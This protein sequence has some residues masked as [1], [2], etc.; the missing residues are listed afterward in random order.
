[1]K[2]FGFF[3]LLLSWLLLSGCVSV[4]L[5]ETPTPTPDAMKETVAALQTENAQL[6]TQVAGIPATIENLPTATPLPSATPT[7]TSTPTA[8]PT[9]TPTRAV[10]HRPPPTATPQWPQILWFTANPGEVDPGQ[11][12]T[13]SWSTS[14]AT[15]AVIQQYGTNNVAYNELSVAPSGSLVLPVSDQ[16]RLWHEFTLIAYNTA[17]DSTSNSIN[18]YIRCPFTYFFDMEAERYRYDCPAGP[19]V[20]SDAAEQYFEGGRMIWVGAEKRI[21]ALLNDGGLY[22][23]ADTWTADQPDVDPGIT[24]P[25]GRYKPV[26]GFGKVWGA[27]PYIR[28]RLGWAMGPE[29]GYQAQV[30]HTWNCCA[31]PHDEF[32]LR[33]FDKRITRFWL[34]QA[35]SGYWEFTKY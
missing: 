29:Q 2:R 13:L 11:S 1:M 16:E 9:A 6:A 3:I 34:G 23:Y 26:R 30:Q 24:P 4:P 21:Y 19:M 14:N 18:V 31:S 8:T 7:A 10:V 32:Y 35:P 5:R 15:R 20:S 12:V 28:S 22:A 33:E 17:G 25:S 27:D